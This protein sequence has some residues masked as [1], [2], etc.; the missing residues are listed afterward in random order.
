MIC[1][2]PKGPQYLPRKLKKRRGGKRPTWRA[3]VAQAQLAREILDEIY[4]EERRR[5]DVDRYLEPC[6]EGE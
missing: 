1:R 4:R 2:Y 5:A 3:L 6:I